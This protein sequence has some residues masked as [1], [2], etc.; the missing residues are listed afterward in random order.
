MKSNAS[1]NSRWQTAPYSV[2][3]PDAAVKIAIEGDAVVEK[4]VELKSS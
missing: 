1:K 2:S 3:K 4:W